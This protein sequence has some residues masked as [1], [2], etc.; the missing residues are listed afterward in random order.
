M[1]GWAGCMIRVLLASVPTNPAHP[2]G[3]PFGFATCSTWG[4]PK[5]AVVSPVDATCST[6]GDPKTAVAPLLGE[7]PRPHWLT[8]LHAL[9]CSP[10]IGDLTAHIQDLRITSICGGGQQPLTPTGGI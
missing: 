4:D 6:W 3:S 2:P 7:T 10:N 8:F 5:T 9:R 1:V